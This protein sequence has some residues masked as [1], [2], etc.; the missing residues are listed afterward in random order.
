[1]SV[2]NGKDGRFMRASL[3][4]HDWPDRSKLRLAVSIVGLLDLTAI[5]L[6]TYPKTAGSFKV[7][8]SVGSVGVITFLGYLMVETIM[9]SDVRPL[10]AKEVTAR[11]QGDASLGTD[12]RGKVSPTQIRDAIAVTVV[13]V[14]LTMLGLV[15]FDASAVASGT[16]ADNLISSFTTLAI[17]VITFYFGSK[18]VDSYVS[19]KTAEKPT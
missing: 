6:G 13:V 7:A 15:L 19:I 12:G 9:R 14:Y 10:T 4:V 3:R 16:S 11:A 2:K 17:F 18:A 5:F 1:M 8:W